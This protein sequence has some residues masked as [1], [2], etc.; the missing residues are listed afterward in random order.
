MDIKKEQENMIMK[1]KKITAVVL[2]LLMAMFVCVPVLAAEPDSAGNIFESGDVVTLPTDPFFGAFA[3]GR[4]VSM[5]N[6][7]A[8]GSVMMA[9]QEVVVNNSEIMESL[10]LAGN[11]VTVGY[12]DVSGNIYAAGNNVVIGEDVFGNGIYAAGSSITFSGGARYACL[13]ASKVT[14]TGVVDGD[15][16]ISAD[17]VTIEEDAVISGTLSINSTNEPVI[18]DAAEIGEY[19]YNRITDDEADVEKGAGAAGI[20]SKFFSRVTSCLYWIVAM[21]A[22]GMLL[23]WLFSDHLDKALDMMKSKPGVMVGTGIISWMA[24]PAAAILLC[25]SYILAPIGAMLMLTYVLLLC[26]GLAFAGASLARFVFPNMNVFLSALIGIAALEVLRMIPFVGFLIGA[27]ADMYLL[28][29]VIQ[30]IWE[31]RMRKNTGSS[32][33]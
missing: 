12:T 22:F 15:L 19:E 21:A 6:T 7:G 18:S 4:S 2:S 25:F 13:A 24:I 32:D 31:R 10:Y 11:S 3:A 16:S 8:E 17:D 9:G 1:K 27:V 5:L 23:C 20:I 28:A 30:S 29:Y 33:I 26:A 14:V